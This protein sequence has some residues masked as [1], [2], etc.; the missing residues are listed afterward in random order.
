M[1][2]GARVRQGLAALR[3]ALA[4]RSARRRRVTLESRLGVETVLRFAQE[5]VDRWYPGT[6]VTADWTGTDYLVQVARGY[7]LAEPIW[8][9]PDR[10]DTPVGRIAFTRELV[11]AAWHLAQ[12]R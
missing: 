1:M 5:V 11:G 3:L 4:A 2:P 12:R 8:V 6:F 7:R 9:A 10:L